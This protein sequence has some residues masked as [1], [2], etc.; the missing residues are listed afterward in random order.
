[1]GSNVIV[2]KGKIYK[3]EDL[4]GI[5]VYENEKIIGLGLY[6]INEDCEIVLLVTYIQN[7]GIGT[8]I[9]NKIKEI[10]IT[11][12]CKR[13][14]LITTNDNIDAIKFYQKKGFY[15]SNIYINAIENS[16]KIKPKI[17]YI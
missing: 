10:A 7:K 2:T 3:A 11:R 4:D 12:N 13:I 17:P 14:W 16:R 1:M 8:Q 5:W 9:F 15:F 6:F